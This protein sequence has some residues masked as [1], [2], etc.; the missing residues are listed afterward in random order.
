MSFTDLDLEGKIPL[1]EVR[2][3]TNLP[4]SMR[5]RVKDSQ[6][7]FSLFHS[8]WNKS[9]FEYQEIVWVA[10]LNQANE[11]LGV[12]EHARGGL[13]YTT[14]DIPQIM[15]IALKANAAGF[16]IAHSH[17]SGDI[18]PS[19]RDMKVTKEFEEAAKYL[20]LRFVDHLILSPFGEYY[21]FL[22]KGKLF[23]D[24]E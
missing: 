5:Y 23:C 12:F 1:I 16:A 7:L 18:E 6:S 15:G 21:S 3:Q 4:K 20:K 11:V 19:L 22:D 17:P 13:S 2:Y 14:M 8:L 24:L 10:L 9:T